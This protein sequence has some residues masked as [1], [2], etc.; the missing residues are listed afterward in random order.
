LLIFFLSYSEGRFG[1]D[2]A[3]YLGLIVPL[4]DSIISHWK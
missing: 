3:N 2:I 1:R 4:A